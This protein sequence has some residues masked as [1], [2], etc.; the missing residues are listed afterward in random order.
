MTRLLERPLVHFALAAITVLVLPLVLRSG[1]LASEILIYGLAA[2]ACNLLLGYTGLL[3][4]GQGIFFGLGSYAGGLLLLRAGWPAPL[5]LPAVALVGA[6]TATAVGWLSIRRQ[7]VYFVMLTLAFSQLF[8]FLAY[9]FS[10]LTG[11][12]NGLLNVPRPRLGGRALSDPWSY[13]AYVAVLFLALFAVLQRVALS[14]FGR[15]LLAIRDNEARASAIG[16]PVRAFKVAAFAISGAVTALAGAL[17]AMLIGVAPLSNI[18]YHTSETLL[19]M[20]II[21]GGANLFASVLGAAFYLVAGDLLSAIWP[22]WLLLLGALLIAI[23][24][25]MQRG[26]WGLV[27]RAAA[28][29]TRAPAEGAVPEESR[30]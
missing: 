9:T 2:A 23:A 1:T 18:E 19:I 21:G 29:V 8:Y 25:F 27:E 10:D 24:L 4:F 5:M 3:S 17:H 12:D 13:Y 6:A 20:T 14:T 11:G 30:P 7:G 22:R 26:L 28:L 15:T 16:F